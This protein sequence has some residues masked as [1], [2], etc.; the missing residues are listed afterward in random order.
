MGFD[1]YDV[2]TYTN[3]DLFEIIGYV[4]NNNPRDLEA[5]LIEKLGS[6][7]YSRLPDDITM[8]AFLKDIYT[9]F[10]DAYE[11]T[12]GTADDFAFTLNELEKQDFDKNEALKKKD[13]DYFIQTG[14]NPEDVFNTVDNYNDAAKLYL[15]LDVAETATDREKEAKLIQLLQLYQDVQTDQGKKMFRFYSEIYEKFFSTDA[16]T[17]TANPP[18]S[19]E[20]MF[21]N[22]TNIDKTKSQTDTTGNVNYSKALDYTKG[23]IN[24]ILKETYKRI[25]SID[26]QYRDAEYASATDFTLNITETLKD[27]VSLKLYAVQIPVTWYTISNSYGSNYFYLKPIDDP[28]TLGIYGNAAHEYRVEINPGNYTQTTLPLQ[29]QKQMSELGNIYTDVKFGSTSFAYSPDD[30]K[31]TLTIDIQKVYNESYYDMI[32]SPNIKSLLKLNDVNINT[33]YSQKFLKTD[34]EIK[35]LVPYEV[36]IGNNWFEIHHYINSDAPFESIKIQLELNSNITIENIVQ[37]LNNKLQN[38]PLLSNSGVEMINIDVSYNIYKF[39]IRLNRYKTQN[40]VG[41]KMRLR[42]PNTGDDPNNTSATDT[43]RILWQNG[44]H[45]ASSDGIELTKYVSYTDVTMSQTMSMENETITFRP[46]PDISGGVYIEN[47]TYN[48]IILNIPDGEYTITSLVNKINEK[49]GLNP[50]L[51]GTTFETPTSGLAVVKITLAINKIYTTKDYRIVFYDIYSFAKCTKASSS[52]RN[53]TADTT[54]GY[55][56]GYK[57]LV[58]YNFTAGNLSQTTNMFLT[59]DGLQT[60]NYYTNANNVNAGS[61]ITNTVV[62]LK[63]DAVLSIYLYNY[64]MIILDDF[65]QNHLNDG[66][67]TVSKRDT[68]VTLPSYAN[69]KN[70]RACDIKKG[71]I[72][73]TSASS[74]TSA[75]TS[76][77][78]TTPLRSGLTEKQVYSVE[79][80]IATQNKS[81]DVFNAGPFIKDMFA[82]LPIKASGVEPGTIYVEFGGTLQQQ[83]R[84]Y[85]GPVNINRLMVKLINDKGD[86]VDLNGANWSFQLVCEQ[87]YQKGGELI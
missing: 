22:Q 70:Y 29:I 36:N 32:I 55:I 21:Q 8:F 40:I 7:M 4:D 83:E 86:V 11:Q 76:I 45:F 17:P 81:R 59:P 2:A 20:V 73:S 78:T 33:I 48:D 57:E 62:T 39:N 44:F 13:A 61:N 49:I 41:S 12:T 80:I 6:Y 87:L 69:R 60:N 58:E 19:D 37:D 68:S 42:F 47:S 66:L 64:F 14:V 54:L 15:L 43:P 51:Y 85:F 67:V 56:L 84:V 71:T 52:Y 30:A 50:L 27:V 53:A 18:T 77:S 9:H 74:A 72:T 35:S 79:Q 75:T 65:N 10:F 3:E 82:L 26:S 34:Y 31:S 28:T 24:P 63:G 23:K 25:I 38:E 5:M 46:K 16:N 1:K